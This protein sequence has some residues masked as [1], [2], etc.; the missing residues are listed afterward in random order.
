MNQNLAR[1]HQQLIKN[2]QILFKFSHGISATSPEL[3]YLASFANYRHTVTQED[4]KLTR[5]EEF[6]AASLFEHV[7]TYILAIQIDTALEALYP[8]RLESAD[9]LIRSASSIARLIRTAF[10]HNPF[11]P[12]WKI[13]R[14]LS[15]KQLTVP[16]IISLDTRGLKG[17]NVEQRHYGGS[18]SLLKLSELVLDRLEH[19]SAKG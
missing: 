10:A 14:P 13:D 17:K 6:V 16:D 7:A 19:D 9:E 3:G 11:A 5:E 12:Q 8:N 4:L 15:N 1:F 18:L 2:A